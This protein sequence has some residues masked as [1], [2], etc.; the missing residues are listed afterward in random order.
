MTI[1]RF[2]AIQN[3]EI[4]ID[5]RLRSLTNYQN[6]LVIHDYLFAAA[7]ISADLSSNT[8][9]GTSVE[10]SSSQG[11]P[12]RLEMVKALALSARIFRQSKDRS[13]EAFKAADVLEMLV[14]RFEAAGVGPRRNVAARQ[15]PPG[16]SALQPSRRTP[17]CGGVTHGSSSAAYSTDV[18]HGIMSSSTRP[19]H[20]SNQPPSRDA[21]SSHNESLFQNTTSRPLERVDLD[22]L[23]SWHDFQPDSLYDESSSFSQPFPDW[24]TATNWAMPQ[25]D[26]APPEMYSSNSNSGHVS[27]EG[28]QFSLEDSN[29]ANG[30]LPMESSSF[31]SVPMAFSD[32]MSTLWNLSTGT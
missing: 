26:A 28:Q 27:A 8:S 29:A 24:G 17:A 23:T 22:A 20:H 4:A 14:G 6:S 19:A 25:G 32:P 7:I 15:N 5:G 1:L 16:S 12:T 31:F 10:K 13:M 2:Q 18:E 3:Q 30:S 21:F 11:L 9:T